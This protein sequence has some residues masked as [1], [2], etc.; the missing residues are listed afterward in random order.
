MSL[1]LALNVANGGLVT[2]GQQ[3]SIAARNISSSSQTDAS[4]KIANL[5]TT[6]SGGVRVVSI[7]RASDD[8]LLEGLLAARSGAGT[9]NSI[10]TALATLAQPISDTQNAQ[11]PTNLLATFTS[12]LQLYATSPQDTAV[13]N[14]AIQSGKDLAAGLNSA[15]QQ[16]D[17]VRQTADT[18][19]ANAVTTLNGLLGQFK[20]VNDLIVNGTGRGQDV[21]DQQDQRD[22]LL[23]QISDIIGVHASVRN[24]ND[25]MLQTDS[26]VMLFDTTPRSVTFQPT[27]NI[28]QG[29]LS[30]PVYVDGVPVT[31]QSGG[32][33]VSSGS[34]AGNAQ[35]ENVIAPAY[36][37]QLDQMALGLISNFSESD[38][39]A[40]PTLP[41]VP[42]LFTAAGL[43]SVPAI[44]AAPAGLAGAIVV[45]SNADPAKGG[46]PNLLRDGGIGAPGNPAYL[47]NTTG[48]SGFSGRLQSLLTALSNP[49]SFD[50]STNLDSKTTLSNYMAQ[51]ASWLQAKNQSATSDTQ[52]KSILANQAATSLSNATGVNID[53][54]VTNMLNI[55]RSYQASAKVLNVVNQMLTNLLQTI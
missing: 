36:G 3:S 43:T 53:Q 48:A 30:N 4:R 26:G 39:S 18:N 31:S 15:S 24:N 6:P 25:M 2:S 33:P 41:A 34:I 49:Q 7:S 12:S 45:N 5:A 27:P 13:A 16:V 40:T 8:G 42:G 32:M 23:K 46:N 50:P 35:I 21:S 1:S 11:A 38:Q 44:T 19:T 28:T 51:S 17:T 54:E 55:E 9:A 29:Q 37:R 10:S 52:Y 14:A 20:S 22:G 47:Y